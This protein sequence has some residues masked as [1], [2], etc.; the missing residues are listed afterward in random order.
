MTVPP[1]VLARNAAGQNPVAL[2]DGVPR[3]PVDPSCSI[4]TR[5][6]FAQ[7]HVCAITES[8]AVRG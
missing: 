7:L 2:G 1:I 3:V 6:E 5:E 4:S 8:G